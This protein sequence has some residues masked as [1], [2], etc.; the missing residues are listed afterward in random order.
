MELKHRAN[1]V[2]TFDRDTS[3]YA[4]EN[5]RLRSLEMELA[6][7]R[8]DR[9]RAEEDATQLRRDLDEVRREADS[10]AR[11]AN[12]SSSEAVGGPFN[13]VEE[14]TSDQEEK[15]ALLAE[16]QNERSRREVAEAELK[17]LQ[18]ASETQAERAESASRVAAVAEGEA[19]NYRAR[20]AEREK[21]T[22]EAERAANELERRAAAAESVVEAVKSAIGDA[23]SESDAELPARVLEHVERAIERATRKANV[24]L[25]EALEESQ[26]LST[27]TREMGESRGTQVADVGDRVAKLIEV[28]DKLVEEMNAQSVE[29]E[30]LDAELERRDAAVEA[31][32]SRVA[33]LESKLASSNSQNARLIEIIEEQG[34]WETANAPKSITA[35]APT[36]PAKSTRPPPR[37]A[38]G[39]RVA[40]DVLA[41]VKG[42]RSG[43]ALL[44]HIESRLLE[45]QSAS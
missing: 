42:A 37:A 15:Y 3:A 10:L 28:R 23:S 36:T 5:A 1:E 11:R 39:R 44:A 13:A 16:L 12:N 35:S 43:S 32:R 6:E 26:L 17:E 21:A 2:I 8:E 22:R 27:K 9:I 31:E 40:A 19:D 14:S 18:L 41:N 7:A 20:A 30:R 25:A 29:L 24:A 34:K 38:G 33:D 45:I 4:S